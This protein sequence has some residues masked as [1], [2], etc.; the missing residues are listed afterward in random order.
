MSRRLIDA[1]E[2][3]ERL[4]SYYECVNKET[5]KSGYTGETLMNYEVVDMI[6]DCLENAPTIDAVE[7]PCKIGDFV[8]AIRSYKGVKHPQRGVVGEMFFTNN[9]QLMI[10]VKHVARG[11]WGEKIFATYEEA[12]AAIDSLMEYEVYT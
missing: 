8:W 9:M 7:L 11:L 2:L 5:S 3:E 4:F 6:T 1:T 12:Q 10:V